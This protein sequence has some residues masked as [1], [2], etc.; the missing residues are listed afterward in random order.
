MT[1]VAKKRGATAQAATSL[2]PPTASTNTRRDGIEQLND[3]VLMLIVG[4]VAEWIGRL[5]YVPSRKNLGL[6]RHFR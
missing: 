2:V 5:D 1:P 6:S 3:D 4:H